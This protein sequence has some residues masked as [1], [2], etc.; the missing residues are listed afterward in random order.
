MKRAEAETKRKAE[1]KKRAEA[2]RRAEQEKRYNPIITDACGGDPSAPGFGLCYAIKSVTMGS[3]SSNSNNDSSSSAED[4]TRL[5]IQCSIRCIDSKKSVNVTIQASSPSDARRYL[6][7][8]SKANQICKNAGYSSGYS[9]WNTG[10][11][12]R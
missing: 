2:E 5:S 3:S 11:S 10:I 8:N 1:A 4:G 7:R 9:V 6:T 12:C